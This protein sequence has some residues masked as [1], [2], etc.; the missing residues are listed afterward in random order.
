MLN[1]EWK[2]QIYTKCW[3]W[4]RNKFIRPSPPSP[5]PPLTT[6]V[7]SSLLSHM[8]AFIILFMDEFVLSATVGMIE[9]VE[10]RIQFEKQSFIFFRHHRHVRVSIARITTKATSFVIS[11]SH[12]FNSI[13]FQC[14][15][16]NIHIVVLVRIFICLLSVSHTPPPPLTA[17]F[18]WSIQQFNIWAIPL[19]MKSI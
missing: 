19:H 6:T 16:A 5:P 10:R 3:S 2:K 1:V 9:Y 13:H 15:P 12:H 8:H 4:Y 17:C 14:I 11:F 7:V 18:V